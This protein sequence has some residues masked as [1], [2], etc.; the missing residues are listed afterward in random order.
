MLIT[1]VVRHVGR[2]LDGNPGSVPFELVKDGDLLLLFERMLRDEAADVGRRRVG[3]A[4]IDARRNLSG[5]CGRWYPVI[6]D[7]HRLCIA[8]K[9]FRLGSGLTLRKLG[10]W[11]LV[12]DRHPPVTGIGV[13]TV[14]IAGTL[15]LVVLLL[16]LL[17][18]PARFNL[19]DG[20]L[21]TL[22]FRLFTTLAGGLVRLLSLCNALSF[23]LPLGCLLLIKSRGSKSVEVKRVW[24]VYDERL[25]FMSRR[26]VL[27]LDDSLDAGDVSRAW[28]V[29]SEAAETARVDAYHFSGG[30]LP[31]KCLVS[32][33]QAWWSQGSEGTW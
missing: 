25:Q 24:E 23:G 17:F 5:V 14:V 11:L 26:D 32:N 3:A 16:L 2:L 27:Q 31:G 15:W 12:Y 4:V 9:G 28:L 7:L 21:L 18:S 8:I 29:W 6:L 22:R 30:P 10:P 19:T 13:L 1:L 20:L 33:R